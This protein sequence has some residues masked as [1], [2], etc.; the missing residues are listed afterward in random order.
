MNVFPTSAMRA[1]RELG[2]ERSP[3]GETAAELSQV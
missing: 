1:A 2:G 3:S